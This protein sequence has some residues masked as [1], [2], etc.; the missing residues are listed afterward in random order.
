MYLCEFYQKYIGKWVCFMSHE[1]DKKCWEETENWNKPEEW[2]SLMD[3][4]KEEYYDNTFVHESTVRKRGHKYYRTV[5]KYEAQKRVD[6][7]DLKETV[8]VFKIM[9]ALFLLYL[10]ASGS[11][12]FVREYIVNSSRY[13]GKA[14]TYQVDGKNK[15][16]Y[17][18]DGS[19]CTYTINGGTFTIIY[20]N[21]F[22]VVVTPVGMGGG[23]STYSSSNAELLLTEDMK[24][25]HTDVKNAMMTHYGFVTNVS[26]IKVT[27][28]PVML[29][30]YVA[31]FTPYKYGDFATFLFIQ[32]TNYYK[33]TKYLKK[34]Q[35]AGGIVMGVC[36]FLLTIF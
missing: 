17:C 36:F 15:I 34:V 19:Q 4:E 21:G 3:W 33:S 2:D 11:K 13:Q 23:I 22:Q 5:A 30:A 24:E 7:N 6:P 35:I 10:F 25:N 1:L 16:I 29:F 32:N 31:I 9:A 8:F 27:A 20:E 12:D 28:V 14:G 26:P 18:P